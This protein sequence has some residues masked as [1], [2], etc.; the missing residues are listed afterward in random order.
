MRAH[1]TRSYGRNMNT[2]EPPTVKIRPGQSTNCSVM[3]AVSG[4]PSGWPVL[5]WAAAEAS[6]H[7]AALRTIHAIAWPRWG[8]DPFGE[9]A[10]NWC[11]TSAPERGTQILE[12]AAQRARVIAPSTTITTHLEAGETAATILKAGSNDTL[13]VVGSRQTRRRDRRSVA[14]AVVR[15]ANGPVAIIG[16]PTTTRKAASQ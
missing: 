10:L 5:D 11:N 4:E 8:L 14:S 2:H 9:P 12:K 3:V 13:I 7:H 6:A 15:L 1:E 16:T